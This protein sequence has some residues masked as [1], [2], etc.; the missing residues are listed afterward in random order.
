MPEQGNNPLISIVTATYNDCEGL[1]KTITS[2]LEQSYDNIEYIIIDGASTDN[3][4]ALLD[5]YRPR[6]ATI[7]SEPDKGISDAFNKGLGLCTGDW[8]NF[9]GAGDV[10]SHQDIVSK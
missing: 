9:L 10:F 4:K 6:I 5:E 1:R 8:I 7:I 2:V 3:T